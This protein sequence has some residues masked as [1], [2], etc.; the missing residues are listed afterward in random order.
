MVRVGTAGLRTFLRC[1]QAEAE[2][3]GTCPV[4]CFSTAVPH[5]DVT[6]SVGGLWGGESRRRRVPACLQVK[7]LER[8]R[9]RGC[10]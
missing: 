7:A 5:A 1:L 6:P 3:A 9:A 8:R 4:P 2:L 10:A